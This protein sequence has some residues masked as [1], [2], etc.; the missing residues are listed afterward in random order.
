MPFSKV[1]KNNIIS[2]FSKFYC[3]FQQALNKSRIFDN[4]LF[5]C[6]KE[7]WYL[8]TLGFSMA[9]LSFSID[10]T[11][12]QFLKGR[13]L[14]YEKLAGYVTGQ[15]G[16]WIGYVILLLI[17]PAI[18]SH[19]LSP[20]SI[21]S[22]IPEIKTILQGSKMDEIF[23]ISTL[24][25]KSVG[26][27]LVA[28]SGIPVGREGPFIHIAC[29]LAMKLYSLFYKKNFQEQDKKNEYLISACA[30]G[31]ACCFSSPIGGVL[32]SI[33]V[34]STYFPVRN[35]W[36]GFFCA[37]SGALFYKLLDILFYGKEILTIYFKSKFLY[38]ILLGPQELAIFVSIG[39]ICGLSGS[40]F[41]FVYKYYILFIKSD[42]SISRF[43]MENWWLYTLLVA[44]IISS[45]SFPG[46]LGKYYISEM[47]QS[48]LIKHMFYNMSFSQGPV[49]HYSYS[50]H[51]SGV[52][53]MAE[54]NNNDY[55]R[56]LTLIVYQFI[57]II[58]IITLPI[59]N[60]L[61]IPVFIIGAAI[62]KM[63]GNLVNLVFVDIQNQYPNPQM[64]NGI[65]AMIG[66]VT[67]T[68]ST[69]VIVF[70]LTGQMTHLL[71]TMISV[72]VANAVAHCLIPSIYDVI[73]MTKKLP[74]LPDLM[75]HSK[76]IRD[77]S[78]SEIM[79][80]AC[81]MQC[82]ELCFTHSDLKNLLEKVNFEEIPIV[83]DKNKFTFLGTVKRSVLENLLGMSPKEW[84]PNSQN[85]LF[86]PNEDRLVITGNR[87][88][89]LDRKISRIVERIDFEEL[90]KKNKMISSIQ[91]LP[92]VT[93]IKVHELFSVLK[94]DNLYVTSLGKLLGMISYK[95]M[96]DQ[97]I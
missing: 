84:C 89:N 61:F 42:R 20:Y 50:N 19:Y 96:I 90:I 56:L 64:L 77:K 39:V 28:G 67:R 49:S 60:G 14:S 74:F 16:V 3:K 33:E 18:L 27:I 59:P 66:S 34:T 31:V 92:N 95:D 72:L 62:G 63:C 43:L 69:S 2:Y 94:I 58:L 48:E 73:I 80:R 1:K 29:I 25:S 41:I 10:F 36:R 17:V 11:M 85:L 40:V 83:D 13:S 71:P 38:N 87:A 46:G 79:R 88:T 91:I 86:K 15:Y 76:R 57:S 30:V 75:T 68:I 70:E 37:I 7:I 97:M 8:I 51:E 52:L 82:V 6:L 9:L 44:F 4:F 22:G 54:D 32:Y 5:E 78:V 93:L 47:T 35:Y 21:G 55:F 12:A 45:A 53:K 81:D 23:T 65:Y 24:I 26:L